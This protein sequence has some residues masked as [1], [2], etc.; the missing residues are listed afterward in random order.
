MDL[1]G[2]VSSW[3]TVLLVR[4]RMRGM[5]VGVDWEAEEAE[6]EKDVAIDVLC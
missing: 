6:D 3:P 2:V 1:E 4:P 5:A